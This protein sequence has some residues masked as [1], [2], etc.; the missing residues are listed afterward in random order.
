MIVDHYEHSR[1]TK[2]VNPKKRKLKD[3]F[4]EQSIKKQMEQMDISDEENEKYRHTAKKLKRNA[5]S[6]NI[7][8]LLN[9]E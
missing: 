7:D 1:D 2:V 8:K 9:D 4:G 3:F 5:S 6:E